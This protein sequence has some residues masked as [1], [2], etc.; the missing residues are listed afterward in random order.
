MEWK[1]PSHCMPSTTPPMRAPM[2]SFISRAALLV[3]VTARI[4]P[5]PRPAGGEE[6]GEPGGQHPRLAGAGAGQHQHR[7]VGRLHGGA[8]LGVQPVEV[9]R[10]T[11]GDGPRGNAAGARG[12]RFVAGN[13]G[14]LSRTGHEAVATNLN[15][16]EHYSNRWGLPRLRPMP[17]R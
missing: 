14:A 5:R 4:S 17:G 13:V 2:R 7:A 3:K 6:M 10:R 16:R 15:I 8:L 1:V 12:G 11:S 9:A